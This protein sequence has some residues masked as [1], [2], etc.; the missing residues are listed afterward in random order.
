MGKQIKDGGSFFTLKLDLLSRVLVR[1]K[2]YTYQIFFCLL[3]WCHQ[4]GLCLVYLLVF[5]LNI[6]QMDVKAIFLYGDHE[7]EIY[8]E[9]LEWF[10][11]KG[12]DDYAYKLK[13][14][15]YGF[16]QAPRQWYKKRSLCICSE[17]FFSFSFSFLFFFFLMMTMSLFLLYVDNMFSVDK[18]AYTIK[19]L[20]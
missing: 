11:V 17:A 12:K 14:I 5:N 13:K 19:R 7:D 15:L 9:Q 6:E 10:Q 1:W 20:K 16:K 2:V 18:E 3:W 8:N 4:L